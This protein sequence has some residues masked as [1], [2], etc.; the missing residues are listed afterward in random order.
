MARIMI[1]DDSGMTRKMLSL[2]ISRE[3][4]TVETAENGADALEKLYKVKYDLVITDMNMPHMDGMELLGRL[5]SDSQYRAVPVVVLSS[6]S[7]PEEIRRAM[8]AGALFYLIKPTDSE[9]LLQCV[10][11]LLKA[12]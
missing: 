12:A 3:G 4:F 2:S 9:K 11:K 5:R 1:V 7:S 6:N 8:K 10:R